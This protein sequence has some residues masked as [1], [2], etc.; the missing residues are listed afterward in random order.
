[1]GP[2]DASRR[3]TLRH[4]TTAKEDECKKL[5]I[6]KPFD[7]LGQNAKDDFATWQHD[8]RISTQIG[9]EFTPR[10]IEIL[11]GRCDNV[12]TAGNVANHVKPTA[13]NEKE[14]YYRSKYLDNPVLHSIEQQQ[15]QVDADMLFVWRYLI[16][17]TTGNIM[18]RIQSADV[19]AIQKALPNLIEDFGKTRAK[20]KIFKSGRAGRKSELELH[21]D[22]PE[23]V[24]A[25]KKTSR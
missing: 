9:V 22:V 5:G 24:A 7:G 16:K 1:M 20:M 6:N 12:V 17:V 18:T 19:A 25:L 10:R 3:N 2:D 13:F 23:H 11:W 21:S 8:L 15:I 4:T 14:M